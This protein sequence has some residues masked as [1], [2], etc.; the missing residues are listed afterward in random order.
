MRRRYRPPLLE[1]LE[2]RT[3]LAANTVIDLLGLYTPQAVSAAGTQAR[4]ISRIENAV[5]VSNQVLANSQIPV[6]IRLAGITLENY[7]ES[8]DL[9]TDLTRL[10]NASDGYMDNVEALRNWLGADLVTLFTS[11]GSPAGGGEET[12]GISAQLYV[13]TGR[14]ASDI[15]YSVVS[16]AT[17]GAPDY[18]LIHELGHNLGATHAVG[19][20]TD[21]GA[22]DYAH[23]YRFTGID[24]V[25]Y[26]DVMAYDPGQEIP[27]FSNPRITYQGVPEGNAATADAARVITEDAPLV[28][29]Y[30]APQVVGA[31]D[32]HAGGYVGGWAYDAS[33]PTGAAKVIVYV[34]GKPT[35]LTAGETRTD[36]L[37]TLGTDAHGFSLSL[38]G[39]TH[40]VVAYAQGATGQVTYLGAVTV[41]DQLPVGRLELANA[42][43]VAGWAFDPD[44]TAPIRVNLVL[45][46]QTSGQPFMSTIASTFRSDLQHALG[47][48]GAFGF[49]FTFPTNIGRGIHRIDVYAVDNLGRQVTLLGSRLVDTNQLAVGYVD[50]LNA[51]TLAGWALDPDDPSM[52]VDI[53]YTIDQNAPE[54]VTASVD[55]PDLSSR[56]STTT[57][58]FAIALPQLSAGPH[59]VTVYAIDNNNRAFTLLAQRVIVDAPAPG[60]HLPLGSLDIA[61]SSRIAGWVYDADAGAHPIM[62]RV[63]IDGVA[64]TPFLASASRSDLVRLY[65]TDQLGFDLRNLG[66]SSGIHHIS[67]YAIDSVTSLPVLIASRIINDS[68]NFGAVTQFYA[69][70]ISGWAYAQAEDLA[71]ALIRVDVDGMSDYLV[72]ADLSSPSVAGALGRPDLGFTFSIDYTPGLHQVAVYMLDP[73]TDAPILI[74]AGPILVPH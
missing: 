55:R 12:I 46:G 45:D 52:P 58:G 59:L 16:Q 9:G 35:V 67:V 51:T 39:G 22:A 69:G 18:T 33:V 65:G 64:G 31:L 23:G 6:T 68:L 34:D 14:G 21:T 36:L 54:R 37:D 8:G 32:V 19:D 5:A 72:V 71:G 47:G 26:H 73:G 17:A 48:S 11:G 24:G 61:T 2:P 13:P 70:M 57:H 28:A 7:T 74:H 25:L 49:S 20:P 40:H 50:I 56:Y 42:T 44:T 30:L 27:Y 43:T 60:R 62:A 63:D 1:A 53:R 4:L 3:L 15:A 10:E 66:L 38:S 41:V 29:A